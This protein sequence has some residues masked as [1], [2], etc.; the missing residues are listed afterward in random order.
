MLETPIAHIESCSKI[1]YYSLGKIH[2]LEK[3]PK[4]IHPCLGKTHGAESRFVF[5]LLT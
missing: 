5:L 2:D 1:Y 4:H 3:H